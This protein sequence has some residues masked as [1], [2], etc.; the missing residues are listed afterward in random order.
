[1]API[2]PDDVPTDKLDAV[3][4]RLE[5]EK[6]QRIDAKVAAGEAT[7]ILVMVINDEPLEQAEQ[8]ALTQNPSATNLPYFFEHVRVRTGVP[9]SPEFATAQKSAEHHSGPLGSQQQLPLFRTI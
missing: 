4:E 5:Q 8:R 9:R 3:I 6:Q 7:K 1:M 2:K